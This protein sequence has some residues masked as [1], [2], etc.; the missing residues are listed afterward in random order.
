MPKR[1]GR[2]REDIYLA[3]VPAIELRLFGLAFSSPA[4]IHTASSCFCFHVSNTLGIRLDCFDDRNPHG[5]IRTTAE[6]RTRDP[7]VLAVTRR[8][9]RNIWLARADSQNTYRASNLFSISAQPSSCSWRMMQ[10]S[11][12]T[13]VIST[14]MHG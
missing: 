6:I 12:A 5:S 4:T 13:A 8:W 3:P 1:S 14:V 11:V 2:F 9:L 10:Y 7:S